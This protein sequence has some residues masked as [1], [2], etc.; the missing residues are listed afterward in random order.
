V[1]HLQVAL[2][3]VVDSGALERAFSQKW[4][5]GILIRRGVLIGPCA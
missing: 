1:D 4:L 3:A 5:I 2:L